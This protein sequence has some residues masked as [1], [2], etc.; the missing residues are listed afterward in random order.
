MGDV[1]ACVGVQE[2]VGGAADDVCDEEVA[3]YTAAAAGN[4]R[5]RRGSP[6]LYTGGAK[7]KPRRG[8]GMGRRGGWSS[9]RP[10]SPTRQLLEGQQQQ[11]AGHEPG[12]MELTADEEVLIEDEDDDED[13]AMDQQQQALVFQPIPNNSNDSVRAKPSNRPEP[14]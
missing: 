2:W 12:A 11:L 4:K 6:S 14:A 7:R 13:D 3:L 10:A 5:T 1:S 8:R 9:R